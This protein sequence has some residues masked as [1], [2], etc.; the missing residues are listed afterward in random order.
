MNYRIDLDPKHRV[1]RVAVKDAITDELAEGCYWTISHVAARGGQWATIFD[2]SKVKSTTLTADAV[3][4]L[5]RRTMPSGERK[6]A[7][8]APERP[9]VIAAKAPAIF[10]LSRMFQICREFLGEEFQVVGSMKEAYE[11]VGACPRDFTERLF[12]RH[13]AA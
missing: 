6:S 11:M 3:R 12:P 4:S 1:I 9:Q 7:I 8:P 13:Q 10:G 2:L 5:A